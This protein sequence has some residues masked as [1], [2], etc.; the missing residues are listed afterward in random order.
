MLKKN[1]KTKKYNHLKNNNK[2]NKTSM[3]HSDGIQQLNS[4]NLLSIITTI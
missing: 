1:W 3:I 4:N 2:I